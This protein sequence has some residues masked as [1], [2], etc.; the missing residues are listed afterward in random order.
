MDD[1]RRPITKAK[2]VT[3]R[4]VSL[5]ANNKGADQSDWPAP[6]LFANREDKFSRVKAQLFNGNNMSPLITIPQSEGN[7]IYM[8]N[9]EMRSYFLSMTHKYWSII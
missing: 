4:Q 6:L 3:T 2:L 5:K 1:G 9:E 8:S 7:R